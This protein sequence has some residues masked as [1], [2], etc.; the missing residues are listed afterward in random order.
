MRVSGFVA[1]AA[2]KKRVKFSVVPDESVRYQTVIC[3]FG[4]SML[5]V[6][7][8]YDLTL[9]LPFLSRTGTVFVTFLPLFVVVIF[10]VSKIG[11]FTT[12]SLS[13]AISGASPDIYICVVIL[14]K[15]N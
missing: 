3:C 4:R 13:A 5:T 9:A 10:F 1:L 8:L 11:V 6:F 2:F 14:F 15:K 12:R 7:V